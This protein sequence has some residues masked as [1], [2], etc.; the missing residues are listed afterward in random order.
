MDGYKVQ[1]AA[2]GGEALDALADQ[3]PDAI[4]LDVLM[5][6]PDG[7]EVCR[8]LGAAG[9]HTPVL[10]LT[11]RDD[12]ARPRRGPRRRR[13]R[14]PR[15]S[16]SRSRSWARGCGRCCGAPARRT[17]DAAA[18]RRPRASTPPATPSPA[19]ARRSSSPAP[20]T[21]CWSC[22]CATRARC[23]TR[24]QIFEQVWGYDFGPELELARG[25]RR[26]T[27]AASSSEP[28]GVIH[29]G[30][31]AAATCCARAVELPAPARP[32]VR[33]G[34]RAGGRARVRRSRTGWCGTRC[35]RS[36]TPPS[37]AR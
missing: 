12:V 28:R 33:R 7:L 37:S 26:A 24:T 11:A 10:M 36:S 31:R 17:T 8:R 20:S 4:V 30:A 29:D 2:D 3:P 25:L 1:V 23:F 5:P 18:L 22:C 32:V 14:L 15:S 13:R 27:C 35:T 9:D 21:C 16:R 6:E 19:T 34:G